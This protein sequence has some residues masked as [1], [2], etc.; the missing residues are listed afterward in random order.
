MH[1]ALHRALRHHRRR[2]H[3]VAEEERVPPVAPEPGPARFDRV[4]V[5]DERQA[6]PQQRPQR[7]QEA[8][9]HART[10]AKVRPRLGVA[11]ER[12]VLAGVGAV[13]RAHH[14]LDRR[15][16]RPAEEQRLRRRRAAQA[17]V[18]GDVAAEERDAGETEVCGDGD[19]RRQAVVAPPVRVL[20]A[21]PHHRGEAGGATVHRGP[22][23]PREEE[24]AGLGVDALP[25]ERVAVVRRPAVVARRE[26]TFDGQPLGEV[27]HPAVEAE[28]ARLGE[29]AGEPRAGRGRGEVDEAGA[30]SGEVDQ[31]Q[32]LA[33]VAA[34]EVAAALGERRRRTRRAPPP[35]RAHAASCQ[36]ASAKPKRKPGPEGSMSPKSVPPSATSI[37]STWSH[38]ASTDRPRA[39]PSSASSV[40]LGCRK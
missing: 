38:V 24:G 29:V 2:E 36:N 32:W 13:V 16:R 5:P 39:R 11:V 19:H 10:A 18:A 12:P 17:A 1:V 26:A 31:E 7:R 9:V 23:R 14:R 28:P 37:A 25:L 30:A 6:G 15:E 21:A 34:D 3:V 33:V 40:K 20:V 8:H 4:R 35:A 22:A 27:G